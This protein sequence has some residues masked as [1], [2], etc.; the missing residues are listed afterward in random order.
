E[1]IYFEEIMLKGMIIGEL[2]IPFEQRKQLIKEFLPKINNWSVC[3]SFCA[4]L[5]FVKK[6]KQKMWKFIN[7]YITSDKP[8]DVRFVVV[9]MLD[10]Y[11]DEE[12]IDNVL[13]K[14]AQIKHNDYYVKM[15]MGWALSVCYIKFPQ[16]TVPCFKNNIFTTDVHNIAIKKICESLRVSKEQKAFVI[17]MKIY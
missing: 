6:E 12:Y 3:D 14:L 4:G 9:T 1:Y 2:K 17:N 7:E 15:A 13:Q 5:K 8:F 11:I 10:Y 16:K